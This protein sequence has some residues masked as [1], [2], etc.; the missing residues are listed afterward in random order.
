MVHFKFDALYRYVSIES[1]L[2]SVSKEV[3]RS[4]YWWVKKCVPTTCIESATALSDDEET[5][6]YL[7]FVWHQKLTPAMKLTPEKW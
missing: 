5:Q 3:S 7:F 6:A 4:L 1:H 2:S